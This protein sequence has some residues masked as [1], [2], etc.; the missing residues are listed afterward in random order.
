[1]SDTSILD[2]INETMHLNRLQGVTY[3]KVKNSFFANYLA[4]LVLLRLQDLKG[5][6]LINDPSHSKLTKFSDKMSDV[7]FWA[8][9]MFYPADREVK[10]RLVDGHEKNLAKCAAEV[11]DARI[12]K[13]MKVPLTSP[14]QIDWDDAIGS[15]LLLKHRFG[16]NS[17]Y[18]NNIT[19]VLHKWNDTS[20]SAKKRAVNQ[21]FMYLM[22]SDPQSV[23]LD[24][25]R[26][27]SG[28]TMVGGLNKIA[29]R[30]IG[31]RKLSEDGEG[32]ATSV[33]AIASTSGANAIVAGKGAGIADSSTSSTDM[34]N[35]LAGLYK[36][37]KKA[38]LQV[39]KKSGV[40][41]KDG[42]IIKRKVKTFVARKFKAPDYLKVV[43][44]QG[45]K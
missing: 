38:P 15:L 22:Q 17:S 24:R 7:N 2:T 20:D 14:D 44:K 32:G 13:M 3:D 34:Q 11:T 45:D 16:L 8:R 30:I 27:L 10:S 43:K 21:V 35:V 33:G 40:V 41:F 1:M 36:L 25:V 12:Q 4:A 39:T 31:F 6:M 23:I 29:Q 9:A 42:K 18:F 28:S 5:L 19:V 37:K 26:T